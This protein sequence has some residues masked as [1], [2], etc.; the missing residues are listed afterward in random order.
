MY[1][2]VNQMSKYRVGDVVGVDERDTQ[3]AVQRPQRNGEH[4]HVA[5]QAYRINPL[6]AAR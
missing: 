2:E 1:P 4:R 6:A 5:G 3:P